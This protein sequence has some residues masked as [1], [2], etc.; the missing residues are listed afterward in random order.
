MKKR[1]CILGSTGSIGTQA[2]DVISQHSDLYEAYVLTAYNNADLL[3][4]QGDT[5]YP[6]EIKMSAN[7]KLSMTNTFDVIDKIK[8]KHRGL[9]T[10][11]CLYDQPLWLNDRIV[12]LP[13]E[14]V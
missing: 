2:L 7:P 12:A 14:Y 5:I 8:N 13:I 9:G 11:L 3:I 6:V 1:I 4:E 10:I